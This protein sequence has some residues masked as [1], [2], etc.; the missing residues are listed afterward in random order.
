MQDITLSIAIAGLWLAILALTWQIITYFISLRRDEPMIKVEIRT[1][2]KVHPPTTVYGNKTLIEIRVNNLGKRP[3]TTGNIGLK[4]PRGSKD[5]Y[6]LM[7]DSFYR[8]GEIKDGQ[9][10]AFYSEQDSFLKDHNLKSR[11]LVAYTYDKAGRCYWSHNFIV[12]W[13]KWL[14]V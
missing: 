8:G 14:R 10:R 5:K 4:M 12:R 2:Y 11:H 7:G 13:I 1:G 9:S 3:I 6:M